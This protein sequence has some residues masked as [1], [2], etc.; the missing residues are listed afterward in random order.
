M[1]VY[2]ERLHPSPW[3]HLI[4]LLAIPASALVLAPVN[5]LAGALTGV[6][7][8]G[9]LI[10][11]LWLLAPVI[12]I[13]DGT[14]RAGRARIALSDLGDT[15]VARALEARQERGPGLDARA[16]LLLR[17]DIDGVVRVEVTDDDD[18]APYWLMSTRRPEELARAITGQP[19]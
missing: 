1:P 13:A 3:L 12:E 8:S 6:A 5:P 7:L 16:W 10:A 2:R 14:L 11:V 15:V 17:G 19:S 18:P 4:A 9:G